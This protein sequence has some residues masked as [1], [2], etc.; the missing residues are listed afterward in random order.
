LETVQQI[1]L[2]LEKQLFL[3][4]DAKGAEE[5]TAMPLIIVMVLGLL[6]ERHLY[7]MP[8]MKLEHLIFILL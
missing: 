2:L 5:Q 3:V 8:F 4:A 6:L 7:I 1:H